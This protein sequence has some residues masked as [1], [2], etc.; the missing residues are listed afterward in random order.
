MYR[1][2]GIAIREARKVFRNWKTGEVLNEGGFMAKV[3]KVFEFRSSHGCLD[4][5]EK[6]DI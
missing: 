6:F 5:G 3:R 2:V 1:L 4:F